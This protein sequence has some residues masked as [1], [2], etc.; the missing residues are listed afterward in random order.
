MRN[1][2]IQRF[3]NLA[4]GSSIFKSLVKIVRGFMNYWGRDVF[5]KID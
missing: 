2:Q 1:T 5:V 3:G 4:R